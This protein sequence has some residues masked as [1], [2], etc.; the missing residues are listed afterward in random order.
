M[1]LNQAIVAAILAYTAVAA[2]AGAR[3]DAP[4]FELG[5]P[6]TQPA[7]TFSLGT[8]LTQPAPSS[9]VGE[10]LVRQT[11]EHAHSLC[12][13]DRE[14]NTMAQCQVEREKCIAQCDES[15]S[16]CRTSPNANMASCSAAKAQCYG[17]N[18]YN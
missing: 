2:P 7:P 15:D 17:F 6:V 1:Y 13:A 18:P 5:A 8:P 14:N 9:A 3:R 16:T 10:P 12:V 4:H 11:C